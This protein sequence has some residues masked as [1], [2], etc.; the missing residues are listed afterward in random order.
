M[1][2]QTWGEVFSGLF[3]SLWFGFISFVPNLLLAIII[4]II[5][6][7]VAGMVGKAVSQLI[8]ALKI[9]SLLKALGLTT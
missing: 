7:V 3:Q 8:T 9:D 2:I 5:G 4:F 1:F 6:W